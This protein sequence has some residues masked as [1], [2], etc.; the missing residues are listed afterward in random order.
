MRVIA[1]TAK[2]TQLKSPKGMDVRPTADRVKEAIFNIL[3]PDILDCCFLDLF[4]GTG[5]I[6]IEALSRGAAQAVLV[7]KK[8]QNISIIKENLRRV[9]LASNAEIL[10]KDVFLAMKILSSQKRIFEI[11]YIDPPYQHDYYQRVLKAIIVC[12][13]LADDGLVVVESSKQQPPP[14]IVTLSEIT[15][16]MLRRQQYGDTWVSFYKTNKRG[17]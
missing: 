8:L 1:G 3:T 10:H 12:E 2:K 9:K 16:L 6:A 5:S 7:E 13:L 15:L 11:I 17:N 4:S 14:K